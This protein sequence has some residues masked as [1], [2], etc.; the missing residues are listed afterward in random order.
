MQNYMAQRLEHTFRTL[1]AR[2]K[3]LDR[4][5]SHM[6]PNDRALATELK[7]ARLAI[8]D[9]MSA[10]PTTGSPLPLPAE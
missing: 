6:T 5:G 4:R 3:K 2:I 9:R 1:D 8:L 10:M 7:R